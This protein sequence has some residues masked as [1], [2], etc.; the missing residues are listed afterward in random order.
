MKKPVWREIQ[1]SVMVPIDSGNIAHQ[2]YYPVHLD[3]FARPVDSLKEME[4]ITDAQEGDLVKVRSARK[5]YVCTEVKEVEEPKQRGRWIEVKLEGIDLFPWPSSLDYYFDLTPGRL[6]RCG[7]SFFDED[8]KIVLDSIE[9]RDRLDGVEDGQ[10]VRVGGRLFMYIDD[11]EVEALVRKEK[12]MSKWHEEQDQV[13]FV[14]DL[15][16]PKQQVPEEKQKE[17]D[18]PKLDP[19]ILKHFDPYMLSYFFVK[20]VVDDGDFVDGAKD[21]IRY[22]F[23][24]TLFSE[25]PN[26][27]VNELR[28]TTYAAV[29]KFIADKG[30]AGEPQPTIKQVLDK[31]KEEGIDLWKLALEEGIQNKDGK[32]VELHVDLPEH[33]RWPDYLLHYFPDATKVDSMEELYKLQPQAHD[34][35]V[36]GDDRLFYWEELVDLEKDED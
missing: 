30:E 27:T 23:A 22:Y 29:K 2:D 24:A 3:R 36:V 1:T 34:H 31:L 4:K 10:Y 11:K 32:W 35:A 20:S 5:M 15:P 17:T 26:M 18:L 33:I 12:Q 8:E 14:N 19:S 9:E 21:K 7:D 16:H 25:Y 13:I 6:V 28:E